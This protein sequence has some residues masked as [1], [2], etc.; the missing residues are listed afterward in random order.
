MGVCVQLRS[1]GINDFPAFCSLAVAP[2][3]SLFCHR[4]QHLADVRGQEVVHFV[5]QGGF[6]QQLAASH[7]V[8]NGDVKVRVAAAPVGDLGERV[9]DE[10][11]LRLG[12]N[13]TDSMFVDCYQEGFWV[14]WISCLLDFKE[15]RTKRGPL[16]N[17]FEEGEFGFF[18]SLP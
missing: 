12:I 3:R 9:S 18:P 11:V 4:R 17:D 1:N 8:S 6:T 2:G 5:A 14:I 16:V 13:Q 10:D 7:Q 15:G